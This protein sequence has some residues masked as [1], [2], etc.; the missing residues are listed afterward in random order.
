[1]EQH[2]ERLLGILGNPDRINRLR[3][4]LGRDHARASIS[5]FWMGPPGA[6]EPA[7]PENL[8]EPLYRL[9]ANIEKD[10]QHATA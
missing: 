5:F 10:F 6:P 1:L 8:M 4:V 2:V 7:I 9:D 3:D